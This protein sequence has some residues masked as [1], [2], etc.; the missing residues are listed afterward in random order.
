MIKK[1]FLVFP[2]ILL[3]STVTFC[4][5]ISTVAGGN[6]GHGGYY[7]DG[8]PATDAEI[9]YTGGI[10]VDN[11]G[12]IYIADG[13]NH[14]LRKVDAV[15][16]F[17]STISGTGLSGF[18]GDGSD[19][20][21]A[22]L[23]LPSALAIDEDQNVY[24]ADVGNN[25]IRRIDAITGFITT[26]AGTGVLGSN[27]DGGVA[28]A[29]NITIGFMIFDS[30]NN[31]YFGDHRKVRK[32]S[33]A[34]IISTIAGDGTWGIIGEGVPATSTH[35][36]WP[37]GMGVDRFNN[38][39]FSDSTPAV[40]K[41]IVSNGLLTRVAGSADN[42]ITP[43]SGDGTPALDCHMGPI[44]IAI[45]DT[46]NIYIADAA[47]HRILKVD[48]DGIV[49]TIAGNGT[50]G[51]SGDGGLATNASMNRPMNVAL[52]KCNNV[53]FVD[54]ANRAVRKITYRPSCA[55]A[56]MA[57]SANVSK[58]SIYPNPTTDAISINHV[59][60]GAVYAVVNTIGA[61]LQ[62]GSLRQGSNSVSIGH[63]PAGVYQLHITNGAGE[64]MVHK[65]VKQ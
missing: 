58:I 8:G 34:G 62:Q 45:D 23:N 40:R 27:G 15:T 32:I 65:I 2:F 31:L 37:Q 4:Q 26:Y 36:P 55:V 14:R 12:N 53:Y 6:S 11:D 59:P 46:G 3:I 9:G 19:A 1:L 52:D 49:R 16:G 35:I 57:N 29:A 42:V 25:R 47:N 51:Y 39:Y 33:P 38:V 30:F 5:I 21:S 43:Y 7:G 54:Q 63:L 20:I 22:K 60:T 64:H 13:N 28:T 50:V 41:I 24:V 48:N 17:I 56:G 18:S 44:G 61:V 10:A